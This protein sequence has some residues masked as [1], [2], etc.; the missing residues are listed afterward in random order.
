MR[1]TLAPFTL[2]YAEGITQDEHNN[3]YAHEATILSL[4]ELLA[5]ARYDHVAGTFQNAHRSIDDFIN[6]DCIIMDC[7]NNKADNTELH[8]TPQLLAERLP[9]VPF[10]T[11][12]SRNHM[13]DKGTLS[14]RPRF[15][16]YFPLSKAY[17]Q[18]AHVAAIKQALLQ[19]VPE[20]DAGAKDAARF[21]F[22]VHDPHGETFTG[23]IPVDDFLAEHV[24]NLFTA[25]TDSTNKGKQKGK[26]A[27][28]GK[29]SRIEIISET[30]GI[31]AQSIAAQTDSTGYFNFIGNPEQII[32][33]GNRHNTLLQIAVGAISNMDIDSARQTY[34]KACRQCIPAHDKQDIAKIWNDAKQYVKG[35]EAE[36]AASSTSGNGKKKKSKQLSLPVIETVLTKN[37]VT[38]RYNV[39]TKRVEVLGLPETGR[40][41]PTAYASI[42][43]YERKNINVELLPLCLTP[44][45]KNAGYN[46]GAQ[47]LR[48]SITAIAKLN[49]FN[50]VLDMI[51]ATTWDKR[52]RISKLCNVLGLHIM[53]DLQT[54]NFYAL[55]IRKFLHQALA[56]G[57]NDEGTRA[58]EFVLVLQ[59]AQ[60]IGKTNLFRALAVYPEWFRGGTV[61]NMTDKDSKIE[62][63]STWICELGELDSTL[64]KEQ[65]SLKGHITEH[66]DTVRMPYGSTWDRT[67]RR[68]CY[69]A[70]VNPEQVHRDDTGS[71]R[72]V[73]L[74]VD[75]I[76]KDYLYSTMF[77][78]EWARQLWRQVYDE[79]YTANP[80]GYHLTADELAFSEKNNEP[81]RVPLK[82]ET[83]LLD[84]IDFEECYKEGP[85]GTKPGKV[86][87][88]YTASEVKERLKL[89]MYSAN[90]IGEALKYLC[91]VHPYC[92]RRI[93]RGR[94]QYL[95]PPIPEIDK[96]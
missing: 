11:V 23:T 25:N 13:K 3:F 54:A 87:V 28:Y 73:Y 42:S 32:T 27:K 46:F 65:S 41:I 91:T 20:F 61:I 70:T 17:T 58:Q 79:L 52:D 49:K 50:P 6:A 30:P 83:E 82:A 72:F 29:Q 43:E 95:L 78:P 60:G 51:N 2:S 66:F 16:V 39:I 85:D 88:W 53:D 59:G 69:C 75:R 96:D 67:P 56:L 4:T 68:T 21:I 8:L 76:D 86:F 93:S 92:E 84:L 33:E 19:I 15:H 22:G 5:V 37:N 36:E 26:Q 89:K 45:F 10:F 40:V 12:Y 63:V 94:T 24:N 71:R 47:F 48:D 7:D 64:K 35:I 77:Q 80:E 34:D 14:A 62:S 1:T 74:H 81:F 90:Q 57:L 18:A 9:N 38:V 55:T 31:I 44:M